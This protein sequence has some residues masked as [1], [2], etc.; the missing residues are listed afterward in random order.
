MLQKLKSGWFCCR[1]T[2]DPL[3]LLLALLLMLLVHI[4]VAEEAVPPVLDHCSLKAA[5]DV[6][7]LILKEAT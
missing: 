7:A 5:I 6:F 4:I 3:V 2:G 1:C